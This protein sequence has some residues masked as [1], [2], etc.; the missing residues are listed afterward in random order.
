MIGMTFFLFGDQ[1]L[2][3]PNLSR[4]GAEFGFVDKI[5]YQ[6]YIN[7]IVQLCFFVI[8]GAF[9][10]IVGL[11]NDR[12]DRKK[13]LIFT[14][15]LGELPCFLTAFAPNYGW[16]LFLRTMTGVGLGGIFPIIFSYLGDYFKPANR[17]VATG[18][19]TLAMGLGIAVGQIMAGLLANS[20]FAGMAGWRISFIIM[21]VPSFPLALAFWFFGQSPTRGAAEVAAM[22]LGE[23]GLEKF[24]AADTVASHSVSLR[25][26]GVV[27]QT[28]TNVVAFAQSIPGTIPWG[29]LFYFIVDYYE[30]TKGFK[31]TDGVL[32]TTVFGGMA[33]LGGF[34]GGYLGKLLYAR[35]RNY[36]VLFCSA[37]VL[38]GMVPTF[39]IV[40]Y[41]G[42]TMGPVLIVA[43][44][45]GL[46]TPMT[47]ANIR[48]ILINTNL[49]ER[50]GAVFGA[51]NLADDLGKGL[52]PFFIGL[53]LQGFSL[54]FSGMTPEQVQAITYNMAVGFWLIC[55]LV[56]LFMLKTMVP[57]ED[58]VTAEV[59]RRA[60]A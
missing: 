9:S 3:S 19:L 52:G 57:D 47:G 28:R 10:L 17:P 42:S 14:V 43:A 32:L 55:G 2:T 21:A 8:G 23:R 35:R 44:L 16:F 46:I 4:I 5:Q 41:S 38:L 31:V 18:W 58:A 49:P 36:L 12:W 39:Y 6:W 51:Y 34:V 26:L 56:W 25:D 11:A 59:R 53:I 22:G 27:F 54:V 13:L 50:R 45:G 29:F 20:D 40:N 15:I 1:N 60:S 30:K 48:A 7:S 24:A 37:T 33:I